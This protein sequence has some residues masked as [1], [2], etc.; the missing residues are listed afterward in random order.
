MDSDG[1]AGHLGPATR[2]G[3]LNA[4]K[5]T[6]LPALTTRAIVIGGTQADPIVAWLVLQQPR[7]V[8]ARRCA[9]MDNC[10]VTVDVLR[11][12]QLASKARMKLLLAVRLGRILCFA[13]KCS[14]Q[15][16]ASL[17]RGA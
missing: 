6:C 17:V 8:G 16:I 15:L 7:V 3:C 11:V 5:L 4:T 12:L 9:S 13:G 10:L 14:C 1:G 2:M